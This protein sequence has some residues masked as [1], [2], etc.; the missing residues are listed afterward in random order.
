VNRHRCNAVTALLFV[1]ASVMPLVGHA[2]LIDRGGGMIYDTNL[3]LTWLAD[4]NYAMTQGYNQFPDTPGTMLWSTAMTWVGNLSYG[5]YTGWR[6]P[7]T[8]QPDATCS[9][10]SYYSTG[11]NCTGSELGEL[12][13]NELGGVAGDS[14]TTTHNSNYDLF[15]NINDTRYYWTGTVLPEDNGL[16]WIF[17]FYDGSQAA[18]DT[19][20]RYYAWA[21][22]DGDIGAVPIPAAFWLFGSGLLG[23]MG[24]AR[25]KAV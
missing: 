13:Y 23:L 8:L 5:G 20:N 6:L 15:Q 21:V 14:I 16:A 10:Q 3:N 18:G 2:A 17:W 24:V 19:V 1:L 12:F 9:D 25:R 22:H 11:Y 4:A 7:T